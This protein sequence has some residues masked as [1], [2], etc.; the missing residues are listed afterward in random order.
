[1]SSYGSS[2]SSTNRNGWVNASVQLFG[3]QGWA[4]C[5][6]SPFSDLGLGLVGSLKFIP[7]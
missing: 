6:S 1:M 4:N 5:W 2:S 7:N 3:C